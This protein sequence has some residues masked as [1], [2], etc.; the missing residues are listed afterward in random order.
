[1]WIRQLSQGWWE[2]LIIAS[3]QCDADA[4]QVSTRRRRTQQGDSVALDLVQI[5][6]VSAARHALEGDPVA[7][8]NRKT[9]DSLQDPERPPSQFAA[10]SSPHPSSITVLKRRLTLNRTVSWPRR[11]AAGGP[12]VT[13]AEHIKVAYVSRICNGSHGGDGVAEA[14]G[15]HPWP[16]FGQ[17]QFWPIHF[18]PVLFG[19]AGCAVY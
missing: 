13:T 2:D 14:S 8:G 1:M 9:L 15:R 18:R 12:S 6:E 19:Q 16:N 5:G 3:Q 11:G 4:L 17:N 7:H 10:K